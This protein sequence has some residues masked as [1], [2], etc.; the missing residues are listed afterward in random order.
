M[1]SASCTAS[2][3]VCR[4]GPI[5]ASA[6]FEST[7]RNAEPAIA[8]ILPRYHDVGRTQAYRIAELLILTVYSK[9]YGL[10]HAFTT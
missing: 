3:I 2:R 6:R 8:H 10:I 4:Y 5:A 7:K 9:E 1:R